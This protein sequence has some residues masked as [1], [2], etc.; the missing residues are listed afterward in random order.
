MLQTN[1]FF[2]FEKQR[3]ISLTLALAGLLALVLLFPAG[4]MG[5]ALVLL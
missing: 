3:R 4:N 5:M 1:F 2:D